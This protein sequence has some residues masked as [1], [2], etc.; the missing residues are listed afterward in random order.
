[1]VDGVICDGGKQAVSK[2]PPHFPRLIPLQPPSMQIQGWTWMNA[3]FGD[4]TGADSFVFAQDYAGTVVSGV[5]Y[6]RFLYNSELIGNFRA[7]P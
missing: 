6:D 5:W 7:G 3:S 4:A 1:M 2:N